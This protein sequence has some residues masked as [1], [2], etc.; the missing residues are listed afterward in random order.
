MTLRASLRVRST[1]TFSKKILSRDPKDDIL[2]S[3]ARHL[4][5]LRDLQKRTRGITEFVPLPF[6]HMEAP[7]FLKG[8]ARRGPTM[9]ECTL[10]HAVARLALHPHITNIQGTAL[11]VS[12]FSM[13]I[14]IA[15]SS[16]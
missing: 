16:S 2:R 14:L 10:M 8:R 1:P 12:R 13:W 9:R 4:L 7:V 11:Q 6:V 5:H 15:A 3:R